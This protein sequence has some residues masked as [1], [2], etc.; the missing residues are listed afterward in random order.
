MVAFFEGFIELGTVAAGCRNAGISRFQYYRW[1]EKYPEFKE[2]MEAAFEI[3]ADDLEE[4]ALTRA[5]AKSDLLLIFTL[6]KFKPQYRDNYKPEPPKKG[7]AGG[8]VPAARRRIEEK[9]K[10]I[11][12]KKLPTSPK[13]EIVVEKVEDDEE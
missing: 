12:G 1:L 2:Q 6:K 9:L 4:E 8:E 11:G 3:V 13:Q 5:K 7:G 10:S